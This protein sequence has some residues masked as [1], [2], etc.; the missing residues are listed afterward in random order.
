MA[1]E[2]SATG[3]FG[4]LRLLRQFRKATRA[5]GRPTISVEFA[6]QRYE[7]LIESLADALAGEFGMKWSSLESATP[8]RGTFETCR[9]VAD[10]SLTESPDWPARL[11]T[12][13]R[14]VVDVIDLE[15][16]PALPLE[17]LSEIE[18]SRR[19]ALEDDPWGATGKVEA[20]VYGF[21]M[22][23]TYRDRLGADV[24][25]VFENDQTILSAVAS[26]RH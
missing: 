26:V 12:T 17:V 18:M 24:Q 7:P 16:H 19:S 6:R 13:V 8:R 5:A 1:S 21:W 23:A 20:S 9:W 10:R 2:S 14:R 3:L 15:G 4:V 11:D 22:M 25:L